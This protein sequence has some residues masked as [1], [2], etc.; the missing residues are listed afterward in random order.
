VH[1]IHCRHKLPLVGATWESLVIQITIQSEGGR[2]SEGCFVGWEV[3]RIFGSV[4]FQIHTLPRRP[5]P[6][7][8]VGL[9]EKSLRGG[10]ELCA[11]TST[12][13]CAKI[14]AIMW[15]EAGLCAEIYTVDKKTWF[16]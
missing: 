12:K 11:R 1:H 2:G 6:H 5:R 9:G 16:F 4:R 13:I 3:W 10:G 8:G 7:F 15:D 14:Y